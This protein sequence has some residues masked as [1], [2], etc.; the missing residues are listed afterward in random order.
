MSVPVGSRES[1]AAAPADLEIANDILKGAD[2][3]APFLKE[4]IGTTRH[5]IRCNHI[6]TFKRGGRVCAS[7]RAL[8][9]HHLKAAGLKKVEAA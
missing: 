2:A 6:P 4:T 1:L 9:E 8:T 7:K 3:I 5:L